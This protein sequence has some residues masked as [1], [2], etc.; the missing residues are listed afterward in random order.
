M[1]GHR[2]GQ[3]VTRRQFVLGACGAACGCSLAGCA[4]AGSAGGGWLAPAS[5][6][7]ER[8]IKPCGPG[9]KYSPK[10][11]VAFVRRKE[12][13]GILWPGAIYDG[14]AA[15]ANYRGPN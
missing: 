9:S 5:G 10:L 2:Q 8:R 12:D 4:S 6:I 13:Y 1:H 15:L 14:Q 3:S 11:A 7:K